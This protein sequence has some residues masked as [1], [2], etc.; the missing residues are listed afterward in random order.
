LPQINQ[1]RR[2]LR[3]ARLIACGLIAFNALP[4]AARAQTAAPPQTIDPLADARVLQPGTF[5]FRQLISW[6]RYDALYGTPSG[7]STAVPLGSVFSDSAVGV[8]SVPALA[9]TQSA[10]A[11][12]TS[13]PFRLNAGLLQTSADARIATAPL[14]AEY[15][16]TKRLTV[17]VM[18]PL[19]E[20]RTTV[21]SRLNPLGATGANVGVNPARFGGAAAQ[22]NAALIAGFTQAVSNLK[23][24][25]ASCGAGSADSRCAYV[26]ANQATAQSLDQFATA[27]ASGLAT[28]YGSGAG[29]GTYFVPL[30]TS[31]AQTAITGKITDFAQQY[32]QFLGAS[33]P[34]VATAP[35]GAAGAAAL[36]Q[37]QD[38]LLIGNGR[39]TVGTTS[40]TSIGDIEIAAAYQLLNTFS[41]DTNSARGGLAYRLTLNGA[42]RIATGEPGAA[43]R[44]FDI[45]TGY[46]QP[47][48][49]L[50]AATDLRFT[51]HFSVTGTGAYTIQ[52]GSVNTARTANP[53]DALLPLA[54]AVPGS[55]S[56]GNDLTL[57]LVPRARLSGFWNFEGQ[58]LLRRIGADRYT[59]AVTGA[60]SPGLSA[61]TEQDVGF[62]FSYSTVS[63]NARNTGRIPVEM[64]FTHLET[65]AGSG[66][67][68]PKSSRDQIALRV[69][70]P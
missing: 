14:V 24:L 36:Q 34:L 37:L 11:S 68:I 65:I 20:T 48:V 6:T 41:G 53:G 43:N 2:R 21:L 16:V 18:V 1:P 57:H 70:L 22:Q 9:V 55:Y 33:N 30:A 45:G 10:V 59:G 40:R 52:L 4:A 67:P 19:V 7:G 28:L 64:S 63:S 5:R 26:E 66:G 44:L 23:G 42:Y 61:A 27:F 15:G 60:G 38:S 46:G 3:L 39:D 17:G 8:A 25:I 51:G 29:S 13:Q 35:A 62:G 56:A 12:L 32:Q 47:G 69:Y 58:Y 50:G 31:D 54:P 49:R